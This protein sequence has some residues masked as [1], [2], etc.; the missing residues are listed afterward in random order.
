MMVVVLQSCRQ[1][2]KLQGAEERMSTLLAAERRLRGEPSSMA[3]ACKKLKR[4]SVRRK[5]LS[6]AR[7]FRVR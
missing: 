6:T 5:A 2:W 3:R 7:V 4:E 1:L